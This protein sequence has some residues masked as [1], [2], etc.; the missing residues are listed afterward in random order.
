[1]HLLESATNIIRSTVLNFIFNIIARRL[2]CNALTLLIMVTL[3]S[4]FSS[5]VAPSEEM[6]SWQD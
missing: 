3:I 5:Q 1:M 4:W 2:L 6:V